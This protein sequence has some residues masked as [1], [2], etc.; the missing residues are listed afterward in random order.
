MPNTH[1]ALLV[2]YQYTE[3]MHSA[4][5]N[6]LLINESNLR[7]SE[8]LKSLEI[9]GVSAQVIKMCVESADKAVLKQRA[10]AKASAHKILK[11]K[12]FATNVLTETAMTPIGKKNKHKKHKKDRKP[13]PLNAYHFFCQER[14]KLGKKMVTGDWQEQKDSS[15]GISKYVEMARKSSVD[16]NAKMLDAENETAVVDAEPVVISDVDEE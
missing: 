2:S 14:L 16:H 12:S 6:E 4:L 15:E 13:R 5:K 11:G 8:L 10:H 1:S 7:S 3:A 9:E